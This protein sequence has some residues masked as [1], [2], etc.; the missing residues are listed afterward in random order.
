MSNLYGTFSEYKKITLTWEN[1]NVNKPIQSGGFL[2][3]FKKK[4]AP[5]RSHI[6]QDGWLK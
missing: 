5:V 1:I 2:S 4:A 6:I 3:K